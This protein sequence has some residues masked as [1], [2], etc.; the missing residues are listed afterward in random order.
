MKIFQSIFLGAE[1]GID[2]L[3]LL[4]V[5]R[6]N[7]F[8]LNNI[9]R[10]RLFSTNIQKLQRA[11]LLHKYIFPEVVVDTFIR[12]IYYWLIISIIRSKR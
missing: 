11:L 4:D 6:T 1:C 12:G 10:V 9:N 3:A 5:I 7:G 8:D 2:S